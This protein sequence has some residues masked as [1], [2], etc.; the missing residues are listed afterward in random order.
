MKDLLN[1]YYYLYP[2]KIGMSSNNYYFEFKNHS[3]IFNL[4]NGNLNE[5]KDIYNLNN[6]MQFNNYKINRIILNKDFE[7]LTKKDNKYYILIELIINDKSKINLKDIIEFNKVK[8]NINLLNRTN[9]IN[10]WKNKVDNIEYTINHVKNKYQ[11][12]YNAS[13]YYIGLTENAISYLKYLG[14]SNT[15]IGICHKRININNNLIEF[16]NPIN[17]VID[18]KV[19][20]LAE[21]YK[22]LFFNKNIDIIDIVNSIKLINMSDIDYIYF[23]V[24][25][26]YPS[27]FF[28]MYDKILNGNEKEEKL[29]LITNKQGDYEYLLYEIWKILKSKI[30]VIGIEWINVSV[31]S[32]R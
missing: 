19:R 17:L 3:F 14:V 27:Y 32:F 22:S 30:N 21:Y 2:D 24:R 5:I 13:A 10:M 6:Y 12:L 28:D 7:I 26:L 23:Y 15:N 31:K 16:Y 1:Y 20:D 29:S 25:M 4:Y 11:V 9:W 8:L 18:Y